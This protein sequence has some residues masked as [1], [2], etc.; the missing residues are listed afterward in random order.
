MANTSFPVR[1]GLN[2]NGQMSVLASNGHTTVGNST[3]NTVI[4]QSTITV[5]N[6]TVNTTVNSTTFTFAN[7]VLS[8][9]TFKVGNSTVNSTIN[10][11]S[12]AFNGSVGTSGQKLMS[13]GTVSVYSD[14][15]GGGAWN[16][17][18]TLSISNVSTIDSTNCFTSTYD[19]YILVFGGIHGRSNGVS[20]RMR[21]F[22]NTTTVDTANV[23]IFNG[24]TFA[25]TGYT[26]LAG[27]GSY[28]FINTSSTGAGGASGVVHI[29]GINSNTGKFL[30]S[31]FVIWDNPI[32]PGFVEEGEIDVES[33]NHYYGG[34]N[35]ITG[36]RLYMSSGNILSGTVKVYGISKA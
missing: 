33:Y 14:M 22:K 1:H 29:R 21:F 24:Q 15:A 3:S 16:Y 27:E 26:T 28:G 30:S 35:T 6:T 25:N 17:I 9:S 11:T 8:N 4:S 12:L 36:F 20:L 19:N 23:Y 5:G 32:N 34:S 18:T 13:N 2:V 31:Q 10:S 7:T